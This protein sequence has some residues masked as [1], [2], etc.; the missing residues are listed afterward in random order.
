[1]PELPEYFWS[2]CFQT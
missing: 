2:L 1:M